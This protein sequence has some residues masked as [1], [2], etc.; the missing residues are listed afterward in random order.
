MIQINPYLNFNGNTEAAFNH[1]KAIFGGE[2]TAVMRYGNTP[3]CEDIPEKDKDLIM[4]ISLPIGGNIIMGTDVPDSMPQVKF[5]TNSYIS[6]TVDSRGEADRI[7]NALAEGGTVEM[8]MDDMF[9]G[10][11]FGSLVDKF[12]M[13][14]M[15]SFPTGEQK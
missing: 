4:H 10:D 11:Y 1:Y 2:F 5:G 3:G 8:P 9:W 13:P 12:G 15:I 14:W 7:F 6:I